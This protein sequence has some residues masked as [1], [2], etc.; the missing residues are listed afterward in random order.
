VDVF[1]IGGIFISRLVIGSFFFIIIF[2]I[3]IFLEGNRFEVE[4]WLR[5]PCAWVTSQNVVL[6]IEGRAIIFFSFAALIFITRLLII[7]VFI[8]V[9]F[10]VLLR[11][12]LRKNFNDQR[13]Q[14]FFVVLLDNEINWAW[15][16]KRDGVVIA[17]EGSSSLSLALE[18]LEF[19]LD[20]DNVFN[21]VTKGVALSSGLTLR[22]L[23]HSSVND[24]TILNSL[25]EVVVLNLNDNTVLKNGVS[26]L[27]VDFDDFTFFE[28]LLSGVGGDFGDLTLLNIFR[29]EVLGDLLDNIFAVVLNLDEVNS[30]FGDLTFLNNLSNGL[31]DD[32]G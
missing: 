19:A 17:I 13:S 3:V 6:N 14:P 18:L 27:V 10:I 8:I 1:I 28:G 16:L 23:V 5:R 20:K 11:S 4:E 22:E 2:L 24:L 31:A 12:V 32:F 26:V 15:S 25:N 30:D 7:V 29:N 9:V 21:N